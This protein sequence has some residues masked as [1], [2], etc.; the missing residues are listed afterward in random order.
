LSVV[1]CATVGVGLVQGS[2]SLTTTSCLLVL[3]SG[4]L[5]L[6]TCDHGGL[7]ETVLVMKCDSGC[8]LTIVTLAHLS[9]SLSLNSQHICCRYISILCGFSYMSF[10]IV[11]VDLT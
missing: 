11:V 10:A 4:G 6:H 1:K 2:V 5:A 9:L 7:S 8:L 3:V